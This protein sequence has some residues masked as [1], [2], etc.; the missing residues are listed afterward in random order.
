MYLDFISAVDYL[1]SLNKEIL[2]NID[3]GRE[4]LREFNLNHL[5]NNLYMYPEI[6]DSGMSRDETNTAYNMFNRF[7]TVSRDPTVVPSLQSKSQYSRN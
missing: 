6:S 3:S 4:Y 7:D 1:Q 2:R 5:K